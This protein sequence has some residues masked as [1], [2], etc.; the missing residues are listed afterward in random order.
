MQN[1]GKKLAGA[2]SP[3]RRGGLRP[4]PAGLCWF[5]AVPA[6]LATAV[7]YSSNLIFAL[8]FVVLSLWLQSAWLCRR[9]L[10]G[11]RW[12][13][14]VP[15]PVFAGETIG[16]GGTLIDNAGLRHHA[17]RLDAGGFVSP[18]AD[19][20]PA[21]EIRLEAGV[22]S[23]RRG[24]QTVGPLALSSIHPFGLWRQ[25]LLLPAAE[26]LVYPSP[27]GEAPLPLAAPVPA[28]L[29]LAADNFQGVRRY[30]PGDPVRR[31][32]WRIFARGGPLVVNQFDGAQGGEA[33][34]L[35]WEQTR[36]ETEAR[37]SQLA[38]WILAA[39]RDGLEY[40]LQLGRLR[41]APRRGAAHQAACLSALARFDAAGDAREA[42]GAAA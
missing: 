11:L 29:R 25:R 15:A 5:A 32:N 40:G 13:P 17:L 3:R 19:L 9:N 34:W 26:A 2:Q 8:A 22:A 38:A 36:G 33:L 41:L 28:H 35:R 37:L 39:R 6:L 7:N 31:I 24:V 18:A 42:Q 4:T 16:V 1:D 14:A 30:A 21:S 12:H 27:A 23:R 20:E 10:R